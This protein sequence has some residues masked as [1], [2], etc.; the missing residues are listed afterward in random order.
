MCHCGRG[1]RVPTFN[2][3]HSGPAPQARQAVVI[4]RDA[5]R[6]SHSVE[7]RRGMRRG[8]ALFFR[9]PGACPSGR[10]AARNA[11]EHTGRRGRARP[12]DTR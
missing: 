3:T 1:V 6:A 8:R 5:A 12:A 9:G 10:T 11:P 7:Q 2:T 4:P